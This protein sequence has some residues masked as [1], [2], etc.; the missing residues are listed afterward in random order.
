VVSG[1]HDTLPLTVRGSDWTTDPY[2]LSPGAESLL[3]LYDAKHFLGGIS[4]YQVTETTD[5]NPQR[6]SLVQQVTWA[7]LR[8]ALGI[9]DASWTAEQKDLA[10]S[11]DPL[12]RI[13]S[14]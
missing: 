6:V 7:Y 13:E 14:K 10:D 3:T 5:E 4:G 12:G 11:N 9:E 2:F 1:D 8:H